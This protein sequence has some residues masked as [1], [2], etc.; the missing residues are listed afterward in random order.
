VVS[1]A[2]GSR[3]SEFG[4]LGVVAGVCVCEA[5][6][7]SGVL[8]AEVAF[9]DGIWC[10]GVGK[11]GE[12]TTSGCCFRSDGVLGGK[13]ARVIVRDLAPAGMMKWCDGSL[14][15]LSMVCGSILSG[16]MLCLPICSFESFPM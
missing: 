2:C 10:A 1:P 9:E 8:G 6:D 7:V 16:F 5:P 11:V 4:V 15:T 13:G 3:V 12:P 14:G